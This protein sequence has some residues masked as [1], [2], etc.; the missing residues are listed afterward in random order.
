MSLPKYNVKCKENAY[1]EDYT[2]SDGTLVAQSDA[3]SYKYFRVEHIKWRVLTTNYNSTGKA[4]LL[5]ESIVDIYCYSFS[6]EENPNYYANSKVRTFLN[7]EFLDSAFTSCAKQL[8]PQTSIM[9][10]SRSTNP[11]SNA[12][13]WNNGVNNFWCSTTYD[14]IFLL[15]EQE[16][17]K[18]EYGF[19]DYEERDSAR[20]R[21]GNDYVKAKHIWANQ[22]NNCCWWLRSPNYETWLF[23]HYVNAVGVSG[24]NAD[25]FIKCNLSYLTA[26]GNGIVPALT[27]SLP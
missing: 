26:L 11:D 22:I 3:D 9:N 14:K 6:S 1:A 10:S 15:S 7:S 24:C 5:A 19:K 8:I 4:L 20:I 18:Q 16:V 13:Q 23:S 17:T 21:S 27:I 2:Y 12:E 25:K